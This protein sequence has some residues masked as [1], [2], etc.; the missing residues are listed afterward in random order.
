M[1]SNVVCFWSFPVASPLERASAKEKTTRT[2][3]LVHLVYDILTCSL[4]IRYI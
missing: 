2:I 3:V 4:L 1:L